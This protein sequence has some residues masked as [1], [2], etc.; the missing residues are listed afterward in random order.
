MKIPPEKRI[1]SVNRHLVE[2][3]ESDVENNEISIGLY[4]DVSSFRKGNEN[5]KLLRHIINEYR[6]RML[7]QKL[8]KTKHKY[9]IAEYDNLMLRI[10]KY[11]VRMIKQKLDKTKQKLEIAEDDKLMLRDWN[12]LLEIEQSELEQG[13]NRVRFQCLDMR[14][15]NALLVAEKKV[16]LQKHDVFKRIVLQE[17]RDANALL[18]AE[19]IGLKKALEAANRNLDKKLAE[20]PNLMCCLTLA[21]FKHPVYASDGNTY[22]KVPL[23]QWISVGGTSPSTREAIKIIVDNRAIKNLVDAHR[24]SPSKSSSKM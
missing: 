11:R 9:E 15:E 5:V 3:A 10:N 1:Q 24:R 12:S 20:D 4:E 13:V 17:E 18:V 23:Q 2:V 19:N 16:L 14:A 22:E 7:K 6:V 8:D 21:P